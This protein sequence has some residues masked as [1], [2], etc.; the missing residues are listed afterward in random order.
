MQ[1]AAGH[2]AAIQPDTSCNEEH[3]E[4]HLAQ[5]EEQGQETYD[6]KQRAEAH[7]AGL[8]GPLQNGRAGASVGSGSALPAEDIVTTTDGSGYEQVTFLAYSM[9][10]CLSSVE[11][12]SRVPNPSDVA[13]MGCACSC[14]LTVSLCPFRQACTMVAQI[15]LQD[16]G[17]DLAEGS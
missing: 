13:F 6:N 11:P 4:P 14:S 16:N 12:V 15:A 1:D 8:E 3:V 10:L 9:P 7:P 2:C 5:H 17:D